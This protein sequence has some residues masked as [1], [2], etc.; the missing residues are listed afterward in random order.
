VKCHVHSYATN[1]PVLSVPL[2]C[3]WP[4]N[5]SGASPAN[6][7]AAG[8]LGLLGSGLTHDAHFTHASAGECDSSAWRRW[9]PCWLVREITNA[10]S[11]DAVTSTDVCG[12]V[13]PLSSPAP[14]V[15]REDGGGGGDGTMGTIATAATTSSAIIVDG[16]TVTTALGQGCCAVG[17]R[18]RRGYTDFD[19][20]QNVILGPP[21]AHN[22]NRATGF[23]R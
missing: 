22:R 3:R 11:G 1:E 21:F 13:G 6:P 15:S 4:Y 10:P 12:T 7:P 23:C 18:G 19:P 2:N 9:P 14:A 20:H 16:S 8:S 5:V 17:S